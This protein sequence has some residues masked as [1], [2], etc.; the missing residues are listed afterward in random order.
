M[1]TC[2]LLVDRLVSIIVVLAAA[3]MLLTGC[4]GS[5]DETTT[6]HHIAT[7]TMSPHNVSTT[8]RI[9]TTLARSSPS[10]A[11]TTATSTT[12]PNATSTTTPK[13]TSTTT[14]TT[15]RTGP[16]SESCL[17]VFDVDRTLTAKQTRNGFVACP[18]P[19][20]REYP[21]VEDVAYGGGKLRI[22]ELGSNIN[23]TFCGNCFHAIVSAGEPLSPERD[24][25]LALLGGVAKTLEVSWMDDATKREHIASPLVLGDPDGEKHL[26]VAKIVQWFRSKGHTIPDKKVHFFDD[27]KFNIKPFGDTHFNAVQISC[28]SRDESADRTVG[29]CGAT[30]AE[31]SSRSGVHLCG[32]DL[33]HFVV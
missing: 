8:A 12:T 22:S 2:L 16:I 17:C 19:S 31:V 11:N 21:N 32:E 13:A 3:P 33:Q 14:P 28:S 24:I 9:S 5:T 7:S 20:V 10:S 25:L 18:G 6:R 30:I 1:Q 23:K 15:T 4:G 26:M 29:L 27:R